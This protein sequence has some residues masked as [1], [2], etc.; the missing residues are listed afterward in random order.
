MAVAV[1]ANLSGCVAELEAESLSLGLLLCI[2][3]DV[4]DRGRPLSYDG[5]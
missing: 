2:V 3:W 5:Q 1:G 4:C